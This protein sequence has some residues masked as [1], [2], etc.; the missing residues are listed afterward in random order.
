MIGR[1]G[2][3]VVTVGSLQIIMQIMSSSTMRMDARARRQ[4][5]CRS[6]SG[7]IVVGLIAVELALGNRAGR[8][9]LGRAGT[10]EERDLVPAA[11]AVELVIGQLGVCSPR[12]I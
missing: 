2:S 5:S 7:Q 6:P 3:D 8:S 4:C 1:S 10:R 11:H 12:G 9:E